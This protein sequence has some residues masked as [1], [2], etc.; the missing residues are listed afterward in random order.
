[1]KILFLAAEVAPYVSVGGLSQVMYFLP[2]SLIRDGHDVRV[3]T[4]RYGA[5]DKYFRH[6]PDLE[7][8]VDTAHLD[9]PVRHNIENDVVVAAAEPNAPASRA[10][11][12]YGGAAT[13]PAPQTD[14]ET[15]DIACSVLFHRPE[16]KE[17]AL[18]YF[19]VNDEYYGLRANVFGYADDHVRFALLSKACLVWL[20]EQKR[21]LED[22]DDDA[23]WPDVIHCHD[24]HTAYFIDLARRDAAFGD[25]LLAIPLVL[26]VH[27]FKFQ[28]N[29]DFRYVPEEDRDDGRLPL[30]PL[31]SPRLQKQNALK[32]GLTHA[33]AVTTVSP[34]HA[35]EVLTPEYAEGLETTTQEIRGKLSGILNG[36]DI[37]EFD[38]ATD[39]IIYKNYSKWTFPKGRAVNKKMLQREFGLPELPNA[40]LLAY[41]GRLSSQK[42]L[43]LLSEALTHL[44]EN[45]EMAQFIAIGGGE[46]RFRDTMNGLKERFPEQVGLYLMPDFRLPRKAFAGADVMVIPSVFEP[47]GIVA[48]EALR[49]G[50]VPLVR[51]TGGLNDSI[52]DF[53]PET[54]TGNG[55]SFDKKD[56]WALYGAMTRALTVFQQKQLWEKLVGNCLA[57]DFSWD[58]AAKEYED[59]YERV[60]REKKKTIGRRSGP[61]YQPLEK[62]FGLDK[63][64]KTPPTAAP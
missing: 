15:P 48:L 22:G 52:E 34:T 37:R 16:D 21:R 29:A 2:R 43:E 9:V 49:Y 39:T 7:L 28:G 62:L 24:W 11:L 44:L 54:K 64:K 6:K 19:L 14:A 38:P 5:T 50:A 33:D 61:P 42:G 1:M 23:W 13:Q 45:N 32:R 60:V 3:F 20:K 8:A 26:T 58:H 46:D 51:R 17:D 63:K 55:F 25:L 12:E 10:A 35:R 59:R 47:G 30:A 40:A 31:N 56:P 41:I 27:N 18:T 53:D 36:L 4:P 57:C